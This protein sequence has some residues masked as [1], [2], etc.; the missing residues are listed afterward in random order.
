M[1]RVVVCLLCLSL[2]AVLVAC[3]NDIPKEASNPEASNP[4]LS[5]PEVSNTE[6]ES[7][8]ASTGS[9]DSFSFSLTWGCYGI[10]SYDSKTGKLVKTT[11]ATHPEDYVTTYR[12]TEEQL[13]RI[14]GW[15]EELQ[16]S[17]YPDV[18]DPQEGGLFSN[19]S[20][21]LILTVQTDTVQKTIR[22]SDIAY[23]YKADNAKGR[24]FLDVCYAIK[25]LLTETEE[26]EALP[27]YE[28][29]YD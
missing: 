26:W 25:T 5:I 23:T 7:E 28:F 16:V 18:Y 19:P 14:Y 6:A 3:Q 29:F 24:K 1:K 2:V 20:M 4:E 9:L 17:G 10:S 27:E 15:I 22:A 12:L 11:D 13:R 8:E 21:T